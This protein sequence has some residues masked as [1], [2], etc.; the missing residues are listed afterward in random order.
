V[1]SKGAGHGSEFVFQLPRLVEATAQSEPPLNPQDLNSETAQRLRILLIDDDQDVADSLAIWFET[2]GY[3]VET[4]SNGTQ[5]IC[6]AQVFAPDIIILDI[7]LP[8]MD[9]YQVARK[10]REQPSTQRMWI[11]ALSGYDQKK[12]S[13]S[14]GSGGFD[15][16]LMKPPNLTLL[17][18]LIAEFQHLKQS[19]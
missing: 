17:Q 7:G 9:G 15:Q 13:L 16:Y 3:Q 19:T 8:N 5:G 4:A 6:T 14:M 12:N 18:D 2:L 11:I 1:Y 10:L